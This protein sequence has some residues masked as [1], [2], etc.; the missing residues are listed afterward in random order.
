MRRCALTD[1]GVD[2]LDVPREDEA[3]VAPAETDGAT[4]RDTATLVRIY[5]RKIGR[6]PLLTAEDEVEL[7]KSGFDGGLFA[8][9]TL[10]GSFTMPGPSTATWSFSSAKGSAP[11][12]A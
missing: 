7:A 12:S 6:V 10:G 4:R 3:E 5:L 11:S 8:E 1:E 2:V 9:E